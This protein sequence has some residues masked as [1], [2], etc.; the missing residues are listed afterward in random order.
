VL[1]HNDPSARRR[2][3]WRPSHARRYPAPSD[4]TQTTQTYQSQPASP[5]PSPRPPPTSSGTTI[6]PPACARTPLHTPPP[7]RPIPPGMA[8]QVD[9]IKSTLKAPG[10]MRLKPMKPT[11]KAPGTMCLK[12][13]YGN[14]L[15]SVA[16]NFNLRRYTLAAPRGRSSCLRQR[17]HHAHRVRRRR[18][19]F[20][21]RRCRRR[22]REAERAGRARQN[23]FSL[24]P[25]FSTLVPQSLPNTLGLCS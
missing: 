5:P 7:P 25:N 22:R 6:F 9:L 11:L 15:S 12:L 10:T 17:H 16:L 20:V 4:H 23:M 8:V 14:L 19:P 2:G 1:V 13:K 24:L 21:R 3:V 18:Q